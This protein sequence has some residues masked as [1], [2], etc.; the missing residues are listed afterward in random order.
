M[1]ERKR[2]E[3][4]VRRLNA[5]LEERVQ[6]RTSELVASNQELESFTYSVSHDLRA[7]L[8]HVDG[9]AQILEE[10]FGPN[11]SAEA[12]KFARKIRQGSQNS[13]T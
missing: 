12:L 1:S 10:E 7:P 13:N 5:E 4:E 3:E 11:M 2:A 9:Y 8:R 6:L